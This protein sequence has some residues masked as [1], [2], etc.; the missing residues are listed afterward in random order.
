MPPSIEAWVL[1]LQ[2]V[3]TN[4]DR[5]KETATTVKGYRFPD[6]GLFISTSKKEVYLATWLSSRAAWM[7]GVTKD[8]WPEDGGPHRVSG[9]WWRDFLRKG[10]FPS[11]QPTKVIANSSESTKARLRNKEVT[12][13]F[14]HYTGT[15]L[16]EV[17][18]VFWRGRRL[19][20]GDFA[21]L[22]PLV[23][24]EI[25][26]DLYEH[27]WRLELLSLDRTVKP[28]LWQGQEAHKRDSLLRSLFGNND[29][30]VVEYPQSDSGIAAKS[31]KD[32][33]PYIKIFR[34][35]PPGLAF[36]EALVLDD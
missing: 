13:I 5:I 25:L 30:L 17:D 1:A 2:S 19:T 24:S 11:T 12:R 26:W 29:Y 3:D 14:R 6:P 36:R 33:A 35:C 9:Q 8:I 16:K 32:C 28:S 7:C 27:N 23:I 10:C 21:G 20:Q 22:K 18:A 4:Q 15:D 34:S 31:W